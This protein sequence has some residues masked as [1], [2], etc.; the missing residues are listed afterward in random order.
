M[1]ARERGPQ[2]HHNLL[3]EIGREAGNKP[4]KNSGNAPPRCH[5]DCYL[6]IPTLSLR[7]QASDLKT[8]AFMKYAKLGLFC[9]WRQIWL[10]FQSELINNIS[11]TNQLSLSI[12]TSIVNETE[13]PP[14][15]RKP[16]ARC[17]LD[18]RPWRKR[19]RRTKQIV[20]IR[21]ESIFTIMFVILKSAENGI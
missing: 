19:V 6:T 10:Q 16:T 8:Q 21:E 13:L 7:E 1:R 20:F 14:T 11:S 2:T 17:H 5:I 12:N 4:R 18:I 3:P 9:C 15:D